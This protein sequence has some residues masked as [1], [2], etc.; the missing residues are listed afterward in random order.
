VLRGND[1]GEHENPG[2]DDGTD[3]QR[4][5][6]QRPER[7]VQPLVAF[8]F[9]LQRGDSF[10]AEDFHGAPFELSRRGNFDL[11]QQLATACRR[12]TET[13]LWSQ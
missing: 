12:K 13:A 1:A 4:D 7:A 11:R 2:A 10:A 3:A 9:G 6:V 8:S 5:E